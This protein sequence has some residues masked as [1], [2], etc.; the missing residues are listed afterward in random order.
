MA[1]WCEQ[2]GLYNAVDTEKGK[3]WVTM[4]NVILNT[5]RLYEGIRDNIDGTNAG[6]QWASWFDTAYELHEVK[7]VVH[8]DIYRYRSMTM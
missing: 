1:S 8:S 4:L 6:Y 2:K 3:Q 7:H 5:I